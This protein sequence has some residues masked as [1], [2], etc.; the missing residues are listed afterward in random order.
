VPLPAAAP[1]TVAPAQSVGPAL[2]SGRPAAFDPAHDPLQQATT[3]QVFLDPQTREMI[4]RVIDT[5]T[6][7][8]NYQVPD[9]A[10]LQLQ[11][12]VRTVLA[13]EQAPQKA[14]FGTDRTV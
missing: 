6:G 12:Y 9:P 4:F 8:V 10:Q 14:G 3:R 2:N 7:M 5:R 1:T 13:K 11:A